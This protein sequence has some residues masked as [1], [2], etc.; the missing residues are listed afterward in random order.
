MADSLRSQA[1]AVV[2]EWILHADVPDRAVRLYAVLQRF[3]DKGGM[4]FPSRKNLAEKLSCS[5][6][7]IDRTIEELVEIGAITVER[8]DRDDGSRTSNL[9]HLR[10]EPPSSPVTTPLPTGDDT[11]PHPRRGGISTPEEAASSPVTTHERK[12]EDPEPEDKTPPTPKGV[13]IFDVRQVFDLWCDLLNHQGAKLDRQREAKITA[14]LKS[15]GMAD[16]CDAIRGIRSSAFHMGDN[17]GG[18]VYDGLGVIL[19]NADNIEKFRDLWRGIT[20]PKAEPAP[21]PQRT[22][23][24]LSAVLGLRAAGADLSEL[25]SLIGT[26]PKE[27]QQAAREAFKRSAA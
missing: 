17:Q 16:V 1:F 14:A 23:P 4:A 25:E 26:W 12:P 2:P 10:A 27:R 18:K 24:W 20:G 11:P 6:S 9:Y 13:T 5:K 8:R 15:H 7:S 3:A 19:K 21:P 22:E